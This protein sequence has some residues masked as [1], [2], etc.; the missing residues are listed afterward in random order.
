MMERNFKWTF[1]EEIGKYVRFAFSFVAC[2][3]PLTPVIRFT[4][5]G[6][7][8]AADATSIAIPELKINLDAGLWFVLVLFVCSKVNCDPTHA[9]SGELAYIQ[10]CVGV[11]VTHSHMDHIGRLTHFVS[12]KHPPRFYVPESVVSLVEAYLLAAQEM[13]NNGKFDSPGEY[14]LN[15]RTIG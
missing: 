8:R 7:S 1:P 11:F 12:R 9:N 14:Q 4:L 5:I 13:S 3:K 2:L 15:H 10:G 6:R